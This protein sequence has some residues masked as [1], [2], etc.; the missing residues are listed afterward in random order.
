MSRETS[1][2]NILHVHG[3]PNDVVRILGNTRM[4]YETVSVIVVQFITSITTLRNVTLFRASAY[5]SSVIITPL[6]SVKQYVQ[7]D[8]IVT[9]I[10]RHFREQCYVILLIFLNIKSKSFK[11]KSAEMIL[12][13]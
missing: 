5:E 4:I 8:E 2:C 11:Y 12:D 7:T 6:Y 10:R 13:T 3:I 1:R 9:S